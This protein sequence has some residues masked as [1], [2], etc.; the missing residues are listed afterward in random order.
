MTTSEDFFF[1]VESV[2]IVVL[3]RFNRYDRKSCFVT[4]IQNIVFIS[5]LYHF[6]V[7]GYLLQP[8]IYVSFFYSVFLSHYI[9]RN[10]GLT[11]YE[12]A[13]EPE[14]KF[15]ENEGSL[16]LGSKEHHNGTKIK[17]LHFVRSQMTL[18]V[19]GLRLVF[20]LFLIIFIFLLFCTIFSSP[21]YS[22]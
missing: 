4:V 5:I 21:L 14:A 15:N 17:D 16:F 19:S 6:P 18:F 12:K 8:W 11:K 7:L 22:F 2:H 20:P 13:R 1:F 3:Y 9:G 10:M